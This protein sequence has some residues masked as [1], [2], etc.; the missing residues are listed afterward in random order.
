M[1]PRKY[2]KQCL[3]KLLEGQRVLWNFFY[4][5]APRA[6]STIIKKIWQPIDARNFGSIA[7]TS[8]TVLRP[9][10]NYNFL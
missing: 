5:V 2:L 6:G 3:R 10:N 7:M 9:Y 1:V 8:S 4:N